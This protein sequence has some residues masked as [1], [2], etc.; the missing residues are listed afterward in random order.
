[1]SELRGTTARAGIK[2]LASTFVVAG[3]V[4]TVMG[5]IPAH[6]ATIDNPV[7]SITVT[8]LNPRVSDPVRTDVVWCVPDSTASGD[9]FTI[10]LP[11]QLTELPRGFNLRDPQ[12]LLVATA[13]I[14]GD[15]AI[16]TFTFTDYVDTRTN[17]CGTA[18]FE[19]RL[20][21]S[22]TPGSQTL[23]Y[24]V[25]GVTPF[26]QVITIRGDSTTTIGRDTARKGAVFSDP[27]DECRT[28]ATACLGWYV[29]SQ[30]G[31]FQTVTITDDGALGA[32]FECDRLTVFLWSVDANGK[33]LQSFRP[34]AADVTVTCSPTAYQ[35]VVSNVPA[36]RLVRVL[37]RATP[38]ALDPTGGVTYL[39]TASV[40]HVAE[41][42]TVEDNNISGRRRSARVG[43]DAVG[44]QPPATTTTTTL[45]PTTTTTIVGQL[46]PVPTTAPPTTVGNVQLPATGSNNS[47]LGAG[48]AM[49]VTG[50]SL[51]L[52]ASRRRGAHPQ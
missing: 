43:G 41:N 19:S 51:I 24:L 23:T 16:A 50:G 17:V 34:A 47:M 8:P 39:N 30:L 35:V 27:S 33:L 18:F 1:M 13:T 14:A 38:A 29:E 37:V 20:D 42:G 26:E 5:A 45:A 44:V 12:G 31:P 22:L 21:S 49:F 46:G 28:V 48:L 36:D 6:A 2:V 9:T 10:T 4:C 11:A 32:S 15:P 52:L 25:N 40:S 3:A 7:T